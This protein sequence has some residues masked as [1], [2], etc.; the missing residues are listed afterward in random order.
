MFNTPMMPPGERGVHIPGERGSQNGSQ[1][2]RY[3]TQH[4]TRTR[5]SQPRRS[6]T[7]RRPV[8]PRQQVNN[9]ARTPSTTTRAIPGY[10][11]HIPGKHL[12]AGCMSE[13]GICETIDFAGQPFQPLQPLQVPMRGNKHR[14]YKDTIVP[15]YA[16]HVAQQ[17]F[18]QGN[19][20]VP[21]FSRQY[22][23]EVQRDSVLKC[24]SYLQRPR[25]QTSN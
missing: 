15:G 10:A 19:F 6:M 23:G 20:R 8:P 2:S 24:P 1:T 5:G 7:A 11:G 12:H 18:T 17:R 14:F 4:I 25:P 3:Q 22:K 9:R 16:G 21:G 13:R